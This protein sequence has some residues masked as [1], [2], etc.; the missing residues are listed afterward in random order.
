[1][2]ATGARSTERP[3][4][5]EFSRHGTHRGNQAAINDIPYRAA[6]R[7]K[8]AVTRAANPWLRTPPPS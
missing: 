7:A 4:S 2:R 6:D 1:L 3:A 8:V 5:F